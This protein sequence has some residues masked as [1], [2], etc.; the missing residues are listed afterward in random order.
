MR[1]DD[2]PVLDHYRRIIF[3]D[4]EF[5]TAPGARPVPVCATALDW[6]SG[7]WVRRWLWRQPAAP[8][9]N[10][11][12]RDL[13]VSFH[14]PA[15]LT[16][17]LVLG[18]PLPP[19]VIDLC[20]E[21]KRAMNGRGWGLGPNLLAALLTH[22]LD[23]APFAD[24]P[25]LQRLGARGGPYTPDERRRLLDYNALDVQAPADLLPWMLPGLDLPR[26][27]LRGRFMVE[28]ARMEYSGIPVNE[29]ELQTLADNWDGIRDALIRETDD[30]YG[31]WAGT[32]FKEARWEQW[33][34]EAGLPWPRLP[35]GRISLHRDVFK[36]MAERCPKVRPVHDLRNLLSQLRHFE[37]PVGP[38]GRARCGLFTFSTITGRNAP[39]ARDFLFAWPRW[40]RGLVQAPPGRALVNLDFAA[41][42]YLIAG[43]LSGDPQILANNREGD[44]YV[45]L[46]KSLGLIPPDGDKNSHARERKVC[47]EIVLACN[48][49]MG[50]RRWPRKS[51]GP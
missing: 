12:D 18:W 6:R 48:Y 23:A 42:E 3:E 22:G 11:T 51:A 4:F 36:K 40:C 10:L 17:R 31:V 26:A 29:K 41:E 25:E 34:R 8:T 13:Y 43:T 20:V 35:S 45:N 28:V 50:R 19:N 15:E 46:G 21:F 9:F 39:A 5:A 16:C 33:V 2:F 27:L 7:V 30:E 24:K 14:V 44:A 47:K 49:G 32:T 1:P 38:D 37:L